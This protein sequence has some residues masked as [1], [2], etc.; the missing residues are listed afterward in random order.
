VAGIS[1]GSPLEAQVS[2]L[3]LDAE[4]WEDNRFE[5]HCDNEGCFPSLDAAAVAVLEDL[6]NQLLLNKIEKVTQVDLATRIAGA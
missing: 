4:I 1:T 5:S 3:T 6:G 2:A